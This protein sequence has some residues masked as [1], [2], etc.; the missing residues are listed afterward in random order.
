MISPNMTLEPAVRLSWFAAV[1]AVGAAFDGQQGFVDFGADLMP[2]EE[3][4]LP[5]RGD[6]ADLVLDPGGVQVEPAILEEPRLPL[7][8]TASV[9]DV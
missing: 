1:K 3:R 9:A 7:P 6:R 8:D 4:V 5:G 2:G